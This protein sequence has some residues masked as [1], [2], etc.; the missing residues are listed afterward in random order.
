[1][2]S[3]P[4]PGVAL[5]AGELL[6]CLRQSGFFFTNQIALSKASTPGPL[7]QCSGIQAVT[8]EVE[9]CPACCCPLPAVEGRAGREKAVMAHTVL[10][11]TEVCQYWPAPAAASAA[12]HVIAADVK[13]YS[14]HCKTDSASVSKAKTLLQD[15]Q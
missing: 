7:L 13:H 12:A 5:C 11:D 14:D 2:A 10:R 1:M 3:L 15:L 8:G 9:R 4:W 6:Y